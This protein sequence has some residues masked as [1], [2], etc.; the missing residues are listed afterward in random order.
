[1]P[2]DTNNQ[3]PSDTDHHFLKKKK[4]L[5]FFLNS[6]IGANNLFASDWD[7]ITCF[8]KQFDI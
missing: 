2:C 8:P 5:H 6:D 3:P 1:M 4:S 7:H